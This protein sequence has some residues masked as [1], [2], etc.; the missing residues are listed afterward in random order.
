MTWSALVDHIKDCFKGKTVEYFQVRLPQILL[1]PFLKA[2]IHIFIEPLI[3][4]LHLTLLTV[5]S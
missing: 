1:G 5:A 3:Q 4:T 2:F